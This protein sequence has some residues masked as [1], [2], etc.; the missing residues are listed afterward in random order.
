VSFTIGEPSYNVRICIPPWNQINTGR[1]CASLGQYTS[2][3]SSTPFL[4]EYIKVRERGELMFESNAKR[5]AACEAECM[6]T[7]NLLSGL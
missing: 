1:F 4:T 6:D 7:Q 2:R 5:L 3:G